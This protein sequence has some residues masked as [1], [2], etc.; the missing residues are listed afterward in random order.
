MALRLAPLRPFSRLRVACGGG[1]GWECLSIHRSWRE[2]SPTRRADARQP[3]LQA[4][5]LRNGAEREQCSGED[6]I[7]LVRSPI[8]ELNRAVAVG[9]AEGPE[10]GLALVDR[11]AH[12]SALKTYHLLG[13]VRGDLLHKLG[14]FARSP[15]RVRGGGGTRG[16]PAR[17][18]VSP[19]PRGGS[20]ELVMTG[21]SNCRGH[22]CSW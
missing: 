4:R 19:A 7:R 21:G 16:Q 10:A 18:D 9:M 11:L 5:A 8:G 1:S 17:A 20:G 6:S 13:S 3:P 14:S 15:R 22:G 2:I 12:E